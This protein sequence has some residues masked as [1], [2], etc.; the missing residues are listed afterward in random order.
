[1]QERVIFLGHVVSSEGIQTDP[2]KKEKI[3]NLPIPSNSDELGSFIAFSGYY[4]RLSKIF[5][6]LPNR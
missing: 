1:M 6:K 4:R 5:L 2:D 3:R